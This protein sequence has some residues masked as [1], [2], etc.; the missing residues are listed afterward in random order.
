MEKIYY[1]RAAL[2]QGE[3]ARDITIGIADCD[4]RIRQYDEDN[5]W[6]NT[7]KAIEYG[8]TDHHLT[9]YEEEIDFE[10]QDNA[11][12]ID[13]ISEQEFADLMQAMKQYASEHKA[14]FDKYIS[15]VNN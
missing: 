8:L 13:F 3:D 9:F 5:G 2:L 11:D 7:M 15:I 12:D 1:K 14:A 4:T 10:W 6:I